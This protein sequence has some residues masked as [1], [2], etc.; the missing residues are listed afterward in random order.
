LKRS[1]TVALALL[2]AAPSWAE[3]LVRVDA[4]WARATILAS[5]PGAVYLTLTSTDGDRLV[6]MESPVADQVMLHATDQAEGISRMSHLETLELPPGQAVTLAPGGMHLMLMGLREKLVEGDSFPMTL[7]F[8]VAGELSV[9]VRVLGIAASGPEAA[10][11][12][13]RILVAAAAALVAT[14]AAANHPGADLDR[15]MAA[16]EPAF[17]P[18]DRPRATAFALV[19][20][21]SSRVSW[22]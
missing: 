3:D 14:A 10:M 7:R 4:P 1:I 20:P 8:E 6:A 17:E 22:C 19:S 5:R 9:D 15:V 21:I 12:S 16:K 11:R 2:C 18:V 13:G